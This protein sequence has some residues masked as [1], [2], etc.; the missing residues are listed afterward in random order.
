MSRDQI[1][2]ILAGLPVRYWPVF[3]WNLVWFSLFQAEAWAE[4]GGFYTVAVTTTGQILIT[5]IFVNDA[6]AEA[7]WTQHAPREPWAALDPQAIA[8]MIE[9]LAG[10]WPDCT[11]IGLLLDG[12]CP[13]NAPATLNSS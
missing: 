4:T 5:G 6:P 2:D 13:A 8:A 10:G 3:L 1:H 11:V 12:P 9:A 7:D